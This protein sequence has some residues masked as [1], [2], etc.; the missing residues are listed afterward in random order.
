MD[1]IAPAHR[2][3]VYDSL[4]VLA[5]AREASWRVR[6][7]EVDGRY[8]GLFEPMG[9][10]VFGVEVWVVL[11]LVVRGFVVFVKRWVVERTL[12]WLSGVRRLC[13]DYEASVWGRGCWLYVR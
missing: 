11:Q 6:W 4:E 9:R 3:E 2:Q 7:V 1:A 8:R 10:E 5:R 13:R 12:S